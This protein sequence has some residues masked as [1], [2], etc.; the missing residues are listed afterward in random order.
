M[1][2]TA[3]T[4]A[5]RERG[6]TVHTLV[7]R[8]IGGPLEVRW[9]PEHGD[10]DPGVVAQF[11]AVIGLSGEPVA[12][13]P[14]TRRRKELI[15][16]SRV[17]ATN[18]LVTAIGASRAYGRGPSVFI[19][20]SGVNAYGNRRPG[21]LLTEFAG[22]AEP[23]DRGFLGHVVADWERAALG[24]ARIPGLRVAVLRTGMVLGR[25]GAT[26]ALERVAKVGL[27][28]R[29]GGGRN[30]WPWISLRDEVG[31]I[32]HVLDG[33]LAGPVNLVG[34]S[35]ATSSEVIRAVARSVGRPF[36][37]PTPAWAL[38]PLGVA[39]ADL[40]LVDIAA[41][42]QRLLDSGYVFAD[43]TVASALRV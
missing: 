21:E 30:M 38:R 32:L 5:L 37:L 16:S 13:L 28:G 15:L 41:V 9:H 35:P 27:A 23:K 22:P 10:L 3:V 36:W 1:I 6:D 42:P 34:P 11:D 14:W 18:T 24:A 25:G 19:N 26:D 12:R 29:L 4:A 8:G 40:L 20:A 43:R 33:D 7:R 2:G 17:S 31:A 39:A